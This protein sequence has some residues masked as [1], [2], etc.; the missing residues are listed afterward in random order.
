MK[1]NDDLK[2]YIRKNDIEFVVFDDNALMGSDKSSDVVGTASISLI[3]LLES[4][5]LK[6]R[7]VVSKNGQQT[8]T[9]DIKIFWFDLEN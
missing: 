2:N 4:K 9:I 6:Q 7:L 8:G 1:Y 5:T 3:S